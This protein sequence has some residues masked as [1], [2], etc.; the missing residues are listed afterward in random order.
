MGNSKPKLGSAG[1]ETIQIEN[2]ALTDN[3]P[4]ADNMEK[5]ETIEKNARMD[6]AKKMVKM[7]LKHK[8]HTPYYHRCGLALTQVFTE[9]EVPEEA[10]E[11]LKADKWI[12]VKDGK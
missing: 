8:S 11:K 5:D 2:P 12:A 1:A 10:V 4:S 9:Y 7:V 6:T 3:T